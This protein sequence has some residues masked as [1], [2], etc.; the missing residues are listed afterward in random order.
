MRAFAP[1]V[2]PLLAAVS[3]AGVVGGCG[4][5]ADS[6]GGTEVSVPTESV[7]EPETTTA[8]E[9][10]PT[11]SDPPPVRETPVTEPVAT[12]RVPRHPAIATTEAA[13]GSNPLLA[14]SPVDGATLYR[15]V[16]LDP[17]GDAYWA[18][19]GTDTSVHLGGNATPTA[20]GARVF[21]E[22]TWQVSAFDADGAPL[23]ISERGGLTP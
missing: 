2:V 18:W 12:D 23:A 16:V 3:I 9:T 22:M 13:P 20:V 19:S 17:N 4:G 15:V 7:A 21:G 5:D 1:R 8:A 6:G 10:V 11:P 14:W